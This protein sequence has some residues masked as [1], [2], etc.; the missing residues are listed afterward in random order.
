ML[1]CL[2]QHRV[3]AGKKDHRP[4]LGEWGG[5]LPLWRSLDVRLISKALGAQM[6]VVFWLR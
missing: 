3:I 2:G 5:E 6:S 1:K 4:F